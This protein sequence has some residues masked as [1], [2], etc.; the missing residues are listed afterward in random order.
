M[1]RVSDHPAPHTFVKSIVLKTVRKLSAVLKNEKH[2]FSRLSHI[3]LDIS[4]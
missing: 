1:M 2:L 3:L 4:E